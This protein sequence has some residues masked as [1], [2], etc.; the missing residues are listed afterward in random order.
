M[1]PTQLLGLHVREEL[2]GKKEGLGR[3]VT[4]DPSGYQRIHIWLTDRAWSSPTR[5]ADVIASRNAVFADSHLSS[6]SLMG[7][8]G[9]RHTD[10]KTNVKS[11]DVWLFTLACPAEMAAAYTFK[12]DAHLPVSNNDCRKRR[13]MAI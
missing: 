5:F 3:R 11:H 6:P 2:F 7:L 1:L 13:I 12:V 4:P 8:N 10:L 9:G